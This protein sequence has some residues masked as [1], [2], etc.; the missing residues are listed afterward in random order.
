M[1][2]G[3]GRGAAARGAD[4]TSAVSP[5]MIFALLLV[6]RL[7]A[8]QHSTIGDCDEGT[9]IAAHRRSRVPPHCSLQLLG[10]N[11]LS[12][13]RH[14]LPDLGILAGICHSKLDLHW[15]PCRRHQNPG[16]AAVDK[17]I[18]LSNPGPAAHI[19]IGSAVLRAQGLFRRCFRCM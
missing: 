7:L 6:P 5:W 1:E 13:P 2:T 15:H 14:R 17:G 3:T 10:A 8:A 12:R 18:Q 19:Y 9:S 4:G 16:I 11:A